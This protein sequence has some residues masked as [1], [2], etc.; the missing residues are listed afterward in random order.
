[1][2][3]HTIWSITLKY[4]TLKALQRSLNPT[5]RNLLFASDLKCIYDAH[6]WLSHDLIQSF[7]FDFSFCES[8]SAICKY[9]FI[10]W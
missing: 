5:G 4:Q 6:Y 7:S 2:H 9:L 8:K 3:K 10:K 1:M